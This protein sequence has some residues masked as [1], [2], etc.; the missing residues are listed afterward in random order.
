ML[1]LSLKDSNINKALINYLKERGKDPVAFGGSA[2]YI[3]A[4]LDNAENKDEIKN[5]YHAISDFI[6]EH[7]WAGVFFAK[8]NPELV[9]VEYLTKEEL[10][11]KN[12]EK[13]ESY[14]G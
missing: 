11:K 13:V 14:L 10:A 6:S 8:Q 12:R 1:I 2:G 5:I 9:K 4:L 7:F 3:K